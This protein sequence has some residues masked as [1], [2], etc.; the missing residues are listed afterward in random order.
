[1][2]TH[3]L[4]IQSPVDGHLGCFHLQMLWVVLLWTRVD[5]CVW[6]PAYGSSGYIPNSEMSGSYANLYLIFW[7]PTSHHFCCILFLRSTSQVPY[8]QGE[9]LYKGVVPGL[10]IHREHLRR[11]PP[12][13]ISKSRPQ[14]NTEISVRGLQ[15]ATH[16]SRY[17]T[18][19]SFRWVILWGWKIG[20][21]VKQL[22]ELMVGQD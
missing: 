3:I 2:D 7:G 20:S 15:H 11:Y 21:V 10:G 12:D 8:T 6:D 22:G 13:P 14:L 17:F 19:M 1:M 4:F 18:N 16:I 5:T 9:G